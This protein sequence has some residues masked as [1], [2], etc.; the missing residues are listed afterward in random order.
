MDE[1][2]GAEG[3]EPSQLADATNLGNQMSANRH[4]NPPGLGIQEDVHPL[5]VDFYGP[6]DAANLPCYH[7]CPRQRVAHKGPR[8]QAPPPP[9]CHRYRPA[10]QSDDGVVRTATDETD[11]HQ[12]QQTPDPTRNPSVNHR[13]SKFHAEVSLGRASSLIKLAQPPFSSA[14]SP[15]AIAPYARPAL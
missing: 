11:R 4:V 10:T 12:R 2:T 3:I 7:L 5:P 1:Q 15:E 14:L 8:V 13:L 9:T 6:D